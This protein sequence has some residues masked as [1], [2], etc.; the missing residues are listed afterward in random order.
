MRKITPICFN[1]YN[2]HL[3]ELLFSLPIHQLLTSKFF[4]GKGKHFLLSILVKCKFYQFMWQNFIIKHSF[5]WKT[6]H[7]VYQFT[8][9]RPRKKTIFLLLKFQ[10]YTSPIWFLSIHGLFSYFFTRCIALS[11]FSFL[12]FGISLWHQFFF[13]SLKISDVTYLK[14]QLLALVIAS[15]KCIYSVYIQLTKV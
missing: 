12:Y 13:S 15:V 14:L 9:E 10:N 5:N 4:D 7:F 11:L 1:W 6:K 8:L 3:Y 2:Y